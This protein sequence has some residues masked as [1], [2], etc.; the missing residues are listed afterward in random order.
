LSPSYVEKGYSKA[1]AVEWKEEMPKTKDS[2]TE[3]EI[4][5]MMDIDMKHMKGQTKQ[6]VK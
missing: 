2:N 3:S 5:S 4:N 1:T 6:I